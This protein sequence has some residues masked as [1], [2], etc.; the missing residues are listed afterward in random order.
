MIKKI[1]F[2]YIIGTII[3][4]VLI[5]LI[6]F[7]LNRGEDSIPQKPM[8]NETKIELL[9][10][11][12]HFN[13]TVGIN[14]TVLRKPL[15]LKENSPKATSTQ[16]VPIKDGSIEIFGKWDQ[17]N[18]STLEIFKKKGKFFILENYGESVNLYELTPKQVKGKQVFIIS[19]LLIGT[20]VSSG[21]ELK[22]VNIEYY[23]IQKEGDMELYDTKVGLIEKYKR[24]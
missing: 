4:I 3:P 9:R 5:C 23:I 2:D 24:I 14:E 16:F 7:V 10:E 13:D 18:N 20:N 1:K 15:I 6:I 11:A 8:D 19:Q 22:G 21:I 12:S 17:G